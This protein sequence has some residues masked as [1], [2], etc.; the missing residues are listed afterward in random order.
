MQENFIASLEPEL[1]NIRISVV[2]PAL[3]EEKVIGRC[4]EA[5]THNDFPKN[6]FEVI[7]VDNGSRDR[8]V[9]I[10]RSFDSLLKI[11]ILGVSGVHISELRNR[12]A[13]LATGR[14]LAFLDADCIA[15]SNWLTNAN[16]LLEDA[17]PGIVGAHYQIPEDATWVGRVWCEDRS[18][19]KVGDVS[20]VPSGDL[21]LRR[22]A[23]L[24]LGGFDES[25]ETNEDFELCRRA[26]T[27]GFTVRSYPDLRVVHLG[28]PRTLQGFYKKQRWQG[29]HVFTV[30]LR[31]PEKRRNRRPVALSLYTVLCLI[32]LFGGSLWGLWTGRW[33]FALLFLVVYIGPFLLIS[34]VRTIPRGKWGETLALTVLYLTFGLARAE[35]I[36]RVRA[37]RGSSRKTA[38]R[39]MNSPGASSSG[40]E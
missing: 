22:E 33:L 19:E 13:A 25:I 1:K 23:F 29:T 2:I 4:L 28:T 34:C 14:F 7:M 36:L 32:L 40:L 27:A 18:T 35:S 12:G 26:A 37:W 10:A 6:A 21:L 24:Q 15:H 31:D 8:T 20:Y 5:L 17:G 30:F 9:E 39:A 11:R 16:R 3:N 38:V